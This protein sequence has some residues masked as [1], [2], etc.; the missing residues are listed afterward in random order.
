MKDA[1]NRARGGHGQAVGGG[2]WRHAAP[3]SASRR[4]MAR[5]QVLWWGEDAESKFSVEVQWRPA[6]SETR[7]HGGGNQGGAGWWSEEAP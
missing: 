6:A 1:G 5:W 4:G 7:E 3:P 2:T